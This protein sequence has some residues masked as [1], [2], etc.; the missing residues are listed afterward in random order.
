[1]PSHMAER[2]PR[3]QGCTA[4][5]SAVPGVRAS[6]T[7]CR[8]QTDN[9]A[10]RSTA[11]AERLRKV[12]E[13]EAYRRRRRRRHRVRKTG[14]P[15][16]SYRCPSSPRDYCNTTTLIRRQR[17][18]RRRRDNQ[19]RAAT[20]NY[21]LMSN[22]MPNDGCLYNIDGIIIID[23]KFVARKTAVHAVKQVTITRRTSRQHNI[24]HCTA[25]TAFLLQDKKLKIYKNT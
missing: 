12:A 25:S 13:E 17:C 19:R 15:A 18:R 14:Q 9:S 3:C 22:P 1:M 5:R 24:T 10:S 23:V 6:T 21:L 8:T 20:T 16:G 4:R 11:P 7:P 2:G